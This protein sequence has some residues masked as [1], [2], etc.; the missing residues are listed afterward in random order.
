MFIFSLPIPSLSVWSGLPQRQ[1][2][3]TV[4][5]CTNNEWRLNLVNLVLSPSCNLQ[6]S[7]IVLGMYAHKALSLSLPGGGRR[8]GKR[9]VR[10]QRLACRSH[11]SCSVTQWVPGY[12]G[13]LLHTNLSPP[14]W[15]LHSPGLTCALTLLTPLP[16]P[17]AEW[18]TKQMLRR[19]PRR[20]LYFCA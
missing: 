14:S 7:R 3:D 20:A 4:L 13:S 10:P 15:R 1:C 9:W 16:L 19:K 17:I 12:P 2:R 18:K 5:W 6:Y 8:G 11:T